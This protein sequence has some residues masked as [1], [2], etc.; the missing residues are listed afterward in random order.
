MA[1]PAPPLPAGIPSFPA[2]AATFDG[3]RE[4]AAAGVKAAPSMPPT[5]PMAPPPLSQP[6][7]KV[8]DKVAA[9]PALPASHF[10][11]FDGERA[12]STPSSSQQ[13]LESLS[14]PVLEFDG[15]SLKPAPAQAAAEY[16]SESQ[17]LTP[18]ATAPVEASGH[19]GRPVPDFGNAP[20]LQQNPFF[21]QW[22]QPNRLFQRQQLGTPSLANM[23]G[24]LG[25]T[26]WQTGRKSWFA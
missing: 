19:G 3:E 23:M 15:S 16:P 13:L 25:S 9:I 11:D 24:M 20:R 4:P 2:P 10:A 5:P 14:K 12:P 1:Y 8:A 18:P 26:Q 7:D 21:N 17:P 22:Q 6:A